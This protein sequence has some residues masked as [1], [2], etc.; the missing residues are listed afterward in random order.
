M[1]GVPPTLALLEPS[2]AVDG[3][4]GS[5]SGKNGLKLGLCRSCSCRKLIL[6]EF[7]SVSPGSP[8][9]C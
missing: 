7:R 9:T 1:G 5:I 6:Y 2:N 3:V 8:P 4:L